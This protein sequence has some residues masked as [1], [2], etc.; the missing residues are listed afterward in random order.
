VASAVA[1]ALNVPTLNWA[2]VTARPVV[3]NEAATFASATAALLGGAETI[4]S[5]D[6]T[7]ALIST[8]L[9]Y[10]LDFKNIIPPL[11]YLK[12]TQISVIYLFLEENLVQFT[13]E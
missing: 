5:P 2:V 6:V 7:T 3:T 10:F 4:T 1:V 9:I 12:Y 13:L 11:E 8:L